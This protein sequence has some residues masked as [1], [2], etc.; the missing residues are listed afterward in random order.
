MKYSVSTSTDTV[1]S[2]RKDTMRAYRGE[3]VG[4]VYK[5]ARRFVVTDAAM[6]PETLVRLQEVELEG[7][8]LNDDG[9]LVPN[10]IKTG[11]PFITDANFVDFTQEPPFLITEVAV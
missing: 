5:P 11:R 6:G 9:T 1:T 4:L 2:I 7:L 8:K 3:I 10:Y